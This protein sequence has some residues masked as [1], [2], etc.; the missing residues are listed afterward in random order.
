M[1]F[2]KEAAKE[3]YKEKE[4]LKIRNLWVFPKIFIYELLIY[5][6]KKFLNCRKIKKQMNIK[7]KTTAVYFGFA[8]VRSEVVPPWALHILVVHYHLP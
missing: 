6:P 5:L 4:T 3:A 7:I 2:Q 8:I 1:A